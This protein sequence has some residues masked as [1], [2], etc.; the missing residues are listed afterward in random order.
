M[1]PWDVKIALQLGIIKP[2]HGKWIVEL[3][4]YVEGVRKNHERFQICRN[5]RI[6][7]KCWIGL[8]KTCKSFSHVVAKTL[9]D[10]FRI[11]K[12]TEGN[13]DLILSPSFF[14]PLNVFSISQYRK[15]RVDIEHFAGSCIKNDTV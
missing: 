7:S 2:L 12:N 14:C 13:N 1:S 15:N 9:V 6:H 4:T 5:N 11:Q 3:H 10:H 8:R